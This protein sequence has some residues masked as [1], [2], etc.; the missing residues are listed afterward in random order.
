[1]ASL[2][3]P[4]GVRP[5][6]GASV[7][8]RLYLRLLTRNW[9]LITAV[10]AV[11]VAL[12]ALSSYVLPSS[13]RS[14]MSFVV[15]LDANSREPSEIYQSELVAQSR[16]RLYGPLAMAPALAA[17]VSDQLGGDPDEARVQRAV[18]ATVPPD[19]VF[20]DITVTDRSEAVTEAIARELGTELPRYAATLLSSQ[21]F[22]A[23]T[24]QLVATPTEV[25][26]TGPGLT[27]RMALGLLGGLVVA[28]VL[29]LIREATNRRVRDLDDLRSVLGPGTVGVH[30]GTSR[31]SRRSPDRALVPL[32]VVLSSAAARERPVALVPVTPGPRAAAGMRHLAAGLS[33]QGDRVVLVDADIDGRHLSSAASEERQ[34]R[35]ARRWRRR[36]GA[37]NRPPADVVDA[38][39]ITDIATGSDTEPERSHHMAAEVLGTAV[40]KVVA[41]VAETADVVLVVTGPVLLRSRPTFLAAETAEVIVLVQRKR[42]TKDRVRTA[43]EVVRQLGSEVGAVV[44][45][46]RPPRSLS[47]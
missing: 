26:A 41:E 3:R 22:P 16:A 6:R 39:V 24:L 2:S 27:G 30:V 17:R 42:D 21:R 29:A 36:D 15:Q 31:W 47:R 40:L 43:V 37:H 44:L 23:T 8:G 28:L 32:S 19:S 10:L 7:E 45:V 11:A 1:M 4:E 9:L 14:T 38:E 46:G 20:I 18:V 13:Y 33:S 35:K 5:N 25:T 34:P 12:G